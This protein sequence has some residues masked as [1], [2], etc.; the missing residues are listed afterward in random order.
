MFEAGKPAAIGCKISRVRPK[1]PSITLFCYQGGIIDK[2][3]N[4]AKTNT[5]YRIRTHQRTVKNGDMSIAIAEAIFTFK[6]LKYNDNFACQ[7][8][9]EGNE[10]A[11]PEIKNLI[12]PIQNIQGTI[13]F[14]FQR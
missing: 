9:A 2:A 10:I 4:R 1:K 3:G 8:K 14:I 11:D 5:I 13:R 6:K 12:F 7:C